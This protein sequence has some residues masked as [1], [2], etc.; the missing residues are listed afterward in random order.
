VN[1][2]TNAFTDLLNVTWIV[3]VGAMLIALF[4]GFVLFTVGGTSTVNEAVK[5]LVI[6]WPASTS[7][8]WLATT[9]TVQ[10]APP[11]RFAVGR[12]TKLAAGEA[13]VTV[14]AIGVPTGH[15]SVNAVPVTFTASL[16]F[17]VTVLG[18]ATFVAPF[19]GVV[20]L[21]LGGASTVKEN[22]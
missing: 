2:T 15:A 19:A 12:N 3:L 4:A 18:V 21:T 9:V 8:T 10:T 5:S 20:L 7:V 14:K 1:A 16:K 22:V 13:G 11:G 6:F 17:T